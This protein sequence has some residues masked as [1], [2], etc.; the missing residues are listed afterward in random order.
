MVTYTQVIK[1]SQDNQLSSADVANYQ[2][3]A[4]GH[5]LLL[6]VKRISLNTKLW[7]TT[8]MEGKEMT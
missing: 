5:S 3:N 7:S 6:I 4:A 2:I 1:N 8:L